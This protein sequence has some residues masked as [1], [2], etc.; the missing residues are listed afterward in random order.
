VR[1]ENP[2]GDPVTRQQ[3][4]DAQD[5]DVFACA[6]PNYVIDKSQPENLQLYHNIVRLADR[7]KVVDNV[8]YRIVHDKIGPNRECAYIPKVLVRKILEFYHSSIFSGH[9]SFAKTII[10]VKQF[11]FWDTLGRDTSL[12][13]RTCQVCPKL[14]GRTVKSMGLMHSHVPL[15]PWTDV[16]SDYYGPVPVSI[17]GSRYVLAFYDMH[18]KFALL[19]PVRNAKAK[20]LI[21]IFVNFVLCMFG[22]MVRLWTD[23]G[24]SYTSKVF[25]DTCKLWGINHITT[26]P[27][28]PWCNPAET[29]MKALGTFLASN[30][31]EDNRQWEQ[32]VSFY[33]LAHNSAYNAATKTSPSYALWLRPL[34]LPQDRLLMSDP[35]DV[36][37]APDLATLLSLRDQVNMLVTHNI[38]AQSDKNKVY[39]DK[40]HRTDSVFIGQIVK[41]PHRILSKADKC[42]TQKLQAKFAGPFVVVEKEHKNIYQLRPY[43]CKRSRSIS[44]H[45]QFIE[46]FFIC[47]D[48]FSL[49]A[50]SRVSDV[51]FRA[52][53]SD[54]TERD[55]VLTEY[56]LAVHNNV[57]PNLNQDAHS[58][59]AVSENS[60]SNKSRFSSHS[61][62]TIRSIPLS[63]T[64]KMDTPESSVSENV[65]VDVAP[66]IRPRRT[67][68]R[69][70][71]LR[72]Y[73]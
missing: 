67:A 15:A 14:K 53:S 33:M 31:Q 6:M 48:S 32:Y 70:G 26:P 11:C 41:I 46:P 55:S 5:K 39:H 7:Y 38:K 4:R 47:P 42:I 13:C 1:L 68:V 27:Y 66:L 73:V 36:P 49:P 17:K 12:F 64:N 28:S 44:V 19:F 9:Y 40:K 23:N 30:C 65:L 20:T 56:N 25:R 24:P 21:Y 54:E 43:G 29:Q 2:E 61:V 22:S 58:E 18:T 45:I 51:N 16:F 62:V 63:E 71:Y 60:E 57:E 34:L 3:L 69:P 50:K 59:R 10:R 8:L 37:L 52:N 72:D 35:N